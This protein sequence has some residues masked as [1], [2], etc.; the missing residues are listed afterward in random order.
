[1]RRI[2][3][4]LRQINQQAINSS[5]YLKVLIARLEQISANV[6]SLKLDWENLQITIFL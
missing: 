4:F 6:N 5:N 2:D 3:Y 1:M